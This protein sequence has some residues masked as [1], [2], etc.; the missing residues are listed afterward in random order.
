MIKIY[1]SILKDLFKKIADFI[2]KIYVK[3]MIL[4]NKYN[5]KINHIYIVKSGLF[6]NKKQKFSKSRFYH[7]LIAVRGSRGSRS[8]K[9]KII[10]LSVSNYA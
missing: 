4:K 5:N 7:K 8:Q 1:F 9:V 2:F 6:E 3:T 10:N